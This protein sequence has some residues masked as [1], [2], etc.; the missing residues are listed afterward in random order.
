MGN[1]KDSLIA[2]KRI[3]FFAPAFFGYENKV[4]DKMISLGASVDAYDVRSV[5]KAYERALLKIDPYLFKKKTENYYT[6][7]LDSIRSR[8]YDYVL[9]VKCDMPTEKVLTMYR[10]AFKNAKF[11]LHMWDSVK[12]IP[13]VVDKFRFFDYISSFDRFDS[14]QY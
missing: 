3:L 13:H 10:S 8:E 4:R 12:N 7:I 1:N 2:G 11:C 5:T 9:F 6:D 14:E